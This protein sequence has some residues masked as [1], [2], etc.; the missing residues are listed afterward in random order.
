[1]SKSRPHGNRRTATENPTRHSKDDALTDL[2][3]EQLLRATRELDAYY[4]LQT[5]FVLL[6]CGRLGMRR[7]ELG[8][9]EA[10]W[11][12]WRQRRI[13]IPVYQDCT[14]GRDGSTCAYC[15]QLAE[16]RLAHAPDDSPLDREAALAERWTPKTDAAAREIPFAPMPRAE[17]VI[18]EFFD[19][20]PDGWP[21]S[22]Q[23]VNR[24]L[25][26]VA[27]IAPDI[28]PDDVYPHALR[29]TAATYWAG[30]GVDVFALQQ[31]LG[32]ADLQ[33]ARQY[34]ASNPDNTERALHFARSG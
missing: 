18:E 32:W 6:A 11:I 8:H 9:L 2:E 23:A 28:N 34:V 30:R 17:A 29:A 5:E 22:C 4:Q 10:S 7:G 3:F 31:L 24:R 25:E 26:T 19:R 1:M 12:D 15:E 13:H 21:H 14:N 20:F 16:Q 33:T 27:E